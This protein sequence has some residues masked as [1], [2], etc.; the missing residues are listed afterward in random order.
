M[1]IDYITG[2]KLHDNPEEQYRQEFEHILVDDLNY[3]KDHMDIEVPLQRGSNRKSEL[4]DLVIYNDETFTQENILAVIE[5]EHAGVDYDNQVLSYATATPALYVGWFSGYEE[6]SKH[7]RYFFRDYVNSPTDFIPIPSLPHYG[8]S[9][10]EIGMYKK[11]ELKPAKNLKQLFNR[12]H[13]YL[14]GNSEIKREENIAEEFIKLLFCKILDENQPGETAKFRITPHEYQTESGRQDAVNRIKDL[15]KDLRNNPSFKD[16]FQDDKIY[17]DNDSI[18]YVI[19]QL[20]ELGLLNPQTNTDALGDAYE[21]F[22][23]STLKGDSGQFFTPREIVRFAIKIIAPNYFQPDEVIFDPACGSGGFLSIALEYIKGQIKDAYKDRNFS[24]DRL[25][26]LLKTFASTHIYGSDIDPLLY[27]IAKSY[28]AIIGDG[29]SNIVNADSLKNTADLPLKK[30]SADIIL[31]NPPFGTKIDV[32]DPNTLKKFELGHKL[33]DGQPVK[34]KVL[35][36]QDPDKLF[37]NLDIEYLKNA[38]SSQKGGRMAI[39]LPKQILSGTEEES[40]ELR[41]WLLSKVQITAIIDLPREAF[42]PYTGT[43]TSLVF[44]KKVQQIPDDY[45]IF[46]AVANTVGHDRRGEPLYE[47]DEKGSVKLDKEGNKLINNELPEILKSWESYKNTGKIK[48]NKNISCFKIAFSD[49]KN[50]QIL[51]LDAWYY[52]PEKNKI[53]K[54]LEDNVGKSITEIQ[55]LGDLVEPNGIFYPGRHRRDYVPKSK[56]SVPFYSGTQILQS[57]PYDLKYEPKDYKPAKHH[58]VKKG[59]LLITRSGSTGRVV[60]V[61]DALDGSMVTEHAIRVIANKELI[62]PYYLYAYLASSKLGKTLLDK[63]IYASVVDHISP[64][65]VESIPIAR[66][67]PDKEKQIADN[68]KESIQLK[69]RSEKLFLDGSTSLDN[70]IFS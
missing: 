31:T 15:Y 58:F 65:F 51:R 20:Q 67:S 42:Q 19:S 3:P 26:S 24:K 6:K 45:D 30:G 18:V 16:M 53:V 46:M 49:I 54:T 37:L 27:R 52:D 68:I 41:K 17:L 4:M 39:V 48:K 14:Y 34:N 13:Y 69:E 38:T 60:M 10:D 61:D 55:R 50:S 9:V 70:D 22:L 40:V 1:I 36:G 25:N 12:I 56:N 29:S 21:V 32:V 63:G 66:L 44:V 57:R 5:I 33:K 47:K 8:E 43:K 23:P 28:M 7:P 11:S 59:W 64:Q 35:E 62:N 2:K